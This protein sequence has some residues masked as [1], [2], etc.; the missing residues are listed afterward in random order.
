M[1]EQDE[2]I[3]CS[4]ACLRHLT[5][6]SSVGL[7]IGFQAWFVAYRESR[8]ATTTSSWVLPERPAG[9]ANKTKPCPG[10]FLGPLSLKLMA[11]SHCLSLLVIL[12]YFKAT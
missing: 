10:T 5:V 11:V 12:A 8:V 2:V 9:S 3:A 4:V 7:V 1:T 6:T